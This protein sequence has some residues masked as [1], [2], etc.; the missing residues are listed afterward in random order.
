MLQIIYGEEEKLQVPYKL[1]YFS[2][3]RISV[4][5][6]IL[7]SSRSAKGRG[8]TTLLPLSALKSKPG[9]SPG[10]QNRVNISLENSER[11][12]KNKGTHLHLVSDTMEIMPHSLFS[13]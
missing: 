7:H 5:L 11:D 9:S 1:N 2:T 10:S 4:T 8:Q 3:I 12:H 6:K 13:L